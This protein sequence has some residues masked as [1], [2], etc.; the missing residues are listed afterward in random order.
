MSRFVLSPRA[1]VDL[2]EI[3]GYTE[4]RWGAEQAETYIRLLQ[5]AIEA[6][7]EDPRKGRACD[8]IR[9]GYRK[10]PAAAH[11][12]FY[13]LANQGIDVVRILHGRM[14]FDRHL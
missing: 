2:E 14:D 8:D 10:Y 1:Q 11:V 9:A 13:R 7:A 5:D 6:V 4:R 12:L 3:W